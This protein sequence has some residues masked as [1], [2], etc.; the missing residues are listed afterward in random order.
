MPPAY[1]ANSRSHYEG[2][3]SSSKSVL[4]QAGR[5]VVDSH[6]QLDEVENSSYQQ[7]SYADLREHRYNHKPTLAAGL[8]SARGESRNKVKSRP[9]TA[10]STNDVVDY[11]EYG[12]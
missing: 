1:V 3:P 10:V 11:S 8:P 7:V 6:S 4:E 12:L 5:S 9:D 2:R